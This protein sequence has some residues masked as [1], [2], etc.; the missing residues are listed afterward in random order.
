MKKARIGP[1]A[2]DGLIVGL[3][4]LLVVMEAWRVLMVAP[5]ANNVAIADARASQPLPG[6][7]P[8]GDEPPPG[9]TR[10]LPENNEP[11]PT[12]QFPMGQPPPGGRLHIRDYLA[13][14]IA[15]ESNP[16]LKL[17]P[18]QA[19]RLLPLLREFKKSTDAIPSSQLAITQALTPEQRRYLGEQIPHGSPP[20]SDRD[21]TVE[22]MLHDAAERL[23]KALPLAS[24]KGRI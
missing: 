20:R 13:G 5:T 11:P 1:S 7:P 9:G 15:L 10:G 2:R 19:R 8:P 24:S 16:K 14:V 23:A 22:Q 21:H 18:A 6:Q 17:T 4:M 3:L 12:G